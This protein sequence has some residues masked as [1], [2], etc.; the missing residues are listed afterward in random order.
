[1]K[2]RG[3]SK[4][5]ALQILVETGLFKDITYA[6][7]LKQQPSLQQQ[8][9]SNPQS[10]SQ[11]DPPPSQKPQQ[12]RQQQKLQRPENRLQTSDDSF[13]SAYDTAEKTVIAAA[14]GT[15]AGQDSSTTETD[16]DQVSVSVELPPPNETFIQ[17]TSTKMQN[18]K[19]RYDNFGE[20]YLSMEDASE[21]QY[22]EEDPPSQALPRRIP[23]R[24]SKKRTKEAASLTPP[25]GNPE[26]KRVAMEEHPSDPIIT[27]SPIKK[28]KETDTS[29]EDSAA[30]TP[31]SPLSK[32]QTL[33]KTGA[34][35]KNQNKGAKQMGKERRSDGQH[36]SADNCGCH[37]CILKLAIIKN[38]TIR[39]DRKF[40]RRF[41]DSVKKLRI[42]HHISLTSHLRIKTREPSR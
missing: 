12:Q 25:E 31:I 35:P 22:S 27:S 37:S 9:Y 7:R 20:T 33:G 40:S 2:R 21:S 24:H 32:V 19:I 30:I 39:S 8:V 38:E 3:I 36:T 26:T 23:D 10:P 18:I 16:I 28:I 29:Q 6:K 11:R 17:G 4:R 14:K 5:G 1:M 42:S 13:Q 34:I 41:V 15:T